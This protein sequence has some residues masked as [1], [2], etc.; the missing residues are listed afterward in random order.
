DLVR[1]A[2]T[3]VSSVSDALGRVHART[4]LTVEPGAPELLVGEV[5][6]VEVFALGPYLAPVFPYA[7]A[8]ALVVLGL[9]RASGR[10][11]GPRRG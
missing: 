1:A 2:S 3:G 10:E 9:L 11:A 6:L 5:A 4:A 8:L 7:C